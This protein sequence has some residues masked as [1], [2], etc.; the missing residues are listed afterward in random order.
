MFFETDQNQIHPDRC[1]VDVQLV[2][3]PQRLRRS[4]LKVRA[5]ILQ[6]CPQ[7][8]SISNTWGRVRTDSETPG[9]GQQPVLADPL[10]VLMWGKFEN[11]WAPIVLPAAPAPRHLCPSQVSESHAFHPLILV[12]LEEGSCPRRP[13]S[14]K[15]RGYSSTA[16][17]ILTTLPQICLLPSTLLL[18]Y[19]EV[20]LRPR[21]TKRIS[22]SPPVTLSAANRP[23]PAQPQTEAEECVRQDGGDGP[24]QE[25]GAPRATSA[26]GRHGPTASRG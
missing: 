5:V 13:V 15:E 7:T 11:H 16:L 25:P 3:E 19:H 22:V 23:S 20:P 24:G 17:S 8:I 12:H 18:R 9:A 4:S 6:V 1:S 10:V 2:S 14:Q 21:Y 26:R